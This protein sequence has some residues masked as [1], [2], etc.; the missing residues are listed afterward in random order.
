V[1]FVGRFAREKQLALLLA[2]WPA[3][4]AR[5][6]AQLLLVGD[7]PLRRPLLDSIRGQQWARSVRWFPFTADRRHL[8]SLLASADL[9]VSPGTAETFGLAALEALASGTPV[10][11]ADAGGVAEQVNASGGGA[12]FRADDA[13][14]LATAAVE[15]LRTDTAPL[16]IRARSYA[17]REHDWDVVFERIMTLYRTVRAR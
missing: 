5:T 2:A 3:I 4:R 11:S 14:A 16:R 6:G 1:V 15:L 9:F 8:A 10:L 12:L 17:V 7:G 13:S